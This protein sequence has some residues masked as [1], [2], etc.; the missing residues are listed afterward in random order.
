[1]D[2]IQSNVQNNG[3]EIEIDL[4]EIF[5]AL[6]KHKIIIISFA[7]I[8][9]ILAGI[10]SMFI[11]SPV[12]DTSLKIDVNMPENY[13]T[14][15][16]EYK[17]PIS[18]NRQYL[19]LITSNDV[20]AN[21]IKDMGYNEKDVT[22]NGLKERISIGN[23]N[24]NDATQNV[25]DITV[26]AD[27]SEESLKLAQTLYA[28]YIEYVDVL[29]K[30]RAISYY[31]DDFSAKLEEQELLLASTKEILQKNEGT[32]EKT[33]QTIN[34]SELKNTGDNMVIANI[35]NPAYTKLS[36]GIAENKQLLNTIEN[37]IRANT[38]NLKLLNLEKQEIAKYKKTRQI[39][40][41]K[42]SI[43]NVAQ[44]SIYLL[45]TPVAP[46]EKSS[47][48]SARNI[49]IGLVIGGML[50]V[51]LALIKVYWFKNE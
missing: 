49:A 13:N 47:P 18:T 27:N 6:W 21:T 15:Y 12:Y 28:S 35:L 51:G 41:T 48:N 39:D 50:G 23:V 7:L 29:T 16:G 3:N 33:P 25:F 19:N 43:I 37:S 31:Y 46:S 42:S 14:R 34:Q 5:M 44:T 22:L 40:K 30:E 26:S 17:L 11:I 45:S 8:G 10:C 9:A 1:M 4:R 20:V 2:E 24:S 36:E 38:E 32:L